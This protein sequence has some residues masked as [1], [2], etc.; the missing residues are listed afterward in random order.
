MTMT[1]NLRLEN[2]QV[3]FN[4]RVLKVPAK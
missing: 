2:S 4:K 3:I 1:I